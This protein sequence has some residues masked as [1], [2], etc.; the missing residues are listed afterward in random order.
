MRRIFLGL[1]LL[2][3][4]FSA[5]AQT[6]VVPGSAGWVDTHIDLTEGIEI[7]LQAQG[8][9][10]YGPPGTFGPSGT[11][12]S[13]TGPGYPAMGSRQL[14]LVARITSGAFSPDAPARVDFSVDADDKLVLR[15]P[16]GFSQSHLW[17]VAND[18]YRF[19]NT[20]EYRVSVSVNLRADGANQK[21][22][23][24]FPSL[25]SQ[26]ASPRKAKYRVV[27]RGFACRIETWDDALEW[28][29]KRDEVFVQSDV[30]V[31]TGQGS[32][33]FSSSITG[34]VMG[35]N[36]GP[37][38]YRVRAGSA[39]RTGGI[40]TGDSF[41][42]P[43]P[44]AASSY[45]GFF[46]ATGKP[47]GAPMLLFEGELE[48]GGNAVVLVPTL[49][50]WDGPPHF[51]Q[52][53]VDS[54]GRYGP[55]I[56][57]AVADIASGR[58][59]SGQYLREGLDLGLPAL[60][61]LMKGIFGY[62]ADRPI[63]L[64]E[65]SDDQYTGHPQ[66]ITL[67]Y[68]IAELVANNN[69]AGLGDG[70]FG[71]TLR[72]HPNIGGGT[73][74]MYI[75]VE[76]VDTS[77]PVYSS[78]VRLQHVNTHCRLHSHAINYQHPGTSGQ[79]QVTCFGGRDDNDDWVIVGPHGSEKSYRSGEPIHNGDIVR[80]EHRLTQ[81]NLHSHGGIA[82]PSSRQQEVTAFGYGAGDSNDN[83]RVE[84]VS[85]SDLVRG[86]SFRLIHVNTNHALHS[87][88]GHSTRWTEFQQEVT[89]FGGR[90]SNDLWIIE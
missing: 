29:G 77:A 25:S 85:G 79:Q 55:R 40:R 4:A 31:V 14:G 86:S 84:L 54:I 61:A 26:T 20:G 70:V 16:P 89:G 59:G 43:A 21:R 27:L 13:Q 22:S 28:D 68:D 69:L 63:G 12:S 45:N 56:A 67:T 34:P 52:G 39:G 30:K 17:L 60:G 72:D 9:V 62:S 50:E 57:Q 37:Y 44:W 53:W 11:E 64:S 71:I 24:L 3:I 23:L 81:R 19:D 6:I 58:S 76:R 78:I 5:H 80:L 36:S 2:S 7:V 75:S 42:S 48:Q 46:D 47:L 51:L 10:S 83:W 38:G 18:N 90:D 1:A 82:S 35:D 49:W 8:S 73:Y 15:S 74:Q 65:F 33:L 32:L 66:A 88:S 41:P 87:H